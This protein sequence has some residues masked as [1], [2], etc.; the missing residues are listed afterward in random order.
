MEFT[1]E[2]LDPGLSGMRCCVGALK[3]FRAVARGVALMLRCWPDPCPVL[4]WCWRD[5][6]MALPGVGVTPAWRALFPQLL[7]DPAWELHR[8]ES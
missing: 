8:V 1:F 3:H 4:T 2:M 5:A 7:L 6:G